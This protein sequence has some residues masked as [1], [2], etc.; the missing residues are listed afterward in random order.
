M[1]NLRRFFVSLFTGKKPVSKK[2]G[3]RLIFHTNHKEL[4]ARVAA[5]ENVDV[6]K[7]GKAVFI[8]RVSI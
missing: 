1:L 2:R 3:S 4:A 6:D 7:E 5:G 8:A